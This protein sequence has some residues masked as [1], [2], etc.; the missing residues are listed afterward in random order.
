M[1]EDHQ[2]LVR[3]YREREKGVSRAVV[4]TISGIT[5]LSVMGRRT[6]VFFVAFCNKKESA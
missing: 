5:L 4:S 6:A 2:Y 3:G 1:L